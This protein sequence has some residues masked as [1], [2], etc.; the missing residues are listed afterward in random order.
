MTHM[1]QDLFERL[2]EHGTGYL[3][4]EGTGNQAQAAEVLG[5]YPVRIRGTLDSRRD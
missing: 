1:C 5:K 3:T 4:A 2:V